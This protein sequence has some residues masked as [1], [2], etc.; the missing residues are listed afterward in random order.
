MQVLGALSTS[1]DVCDVARLLWLG[2]VSRRCWYSSL[3]LINLALVST[4]NQAVQNIIVNGNNQEKYFSNNASKMAD[5]N[6]YINDEDYFVF[7]ILFHHYKIILKELLQ[8]I[9]PNYL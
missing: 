7:E 1:S 8:K 5:D 3:S 4:W 2:L 9:N 6:N